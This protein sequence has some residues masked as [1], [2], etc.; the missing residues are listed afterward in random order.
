VLPE[1]VRLQHTRWGEVESGE[2]RIDDMIW[3]EDLS[4]SNNDDRQHRGTIPGVV[5]LS[6]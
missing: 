3:V 2:V 1:T 4:M 5:G 6:L